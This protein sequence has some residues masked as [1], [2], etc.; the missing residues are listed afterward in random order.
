VEVAALPANQFFQ[1]DVAPKI[2]KAVIEHTALEAT[3]DDADGIGGVGEVK[4]DPPIRECRA[5]AAPIA[6][7][8]LALPH[9]LNLRRQHGRSIPSTQPSVGE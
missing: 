4:D 8:I 7:R 2:E 3:G 9:R 5:Q 1:V 6:S